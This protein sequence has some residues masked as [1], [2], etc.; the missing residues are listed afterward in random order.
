MIS[1]VF[2]SFSHTYEY[3]LCVTFANFHSQLYWTYKRIT[4]TKMEELNPNQTWWTK[5]AIG[6]H[7]QA[8][9]NWPLYFA[10]N[11]RVRLS[12]WLRYIYSR[13][14]FIHTHTQ[15]VKLIQVQMLWKLYIFRMTQ[16]KFPWGHLVSQITI[17]HTHTHTRT[18]S[19]TECH[20]KNYLR[21]S[22]HRF[23][24]SNTKCM[25]TNEQLTCRNI[26]VIST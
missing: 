9:H 26:I 25:P 16:S 2:V 24:Q 5:N 18:Q 3:G 20:L 19:R 7:V 21:H 4:N 17:T 11:I 6:T 12:I 1:G 13:E 15:A 23:V 10:D 22:Q 14:E 8:I